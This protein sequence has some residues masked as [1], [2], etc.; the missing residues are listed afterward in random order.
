MINKETLLLRNKRPSFWMSDKEY[1]LVT[2]ETPIPTV[3]LV[4]LKKSNNIW[5]TLLLVR[6]TG[7]AKGQWCIIGGRI[8]IGETLKQ[9]IDRQAEDLKVKVKII[10]PFNPNFPGFIDDRNT[11]DKTK[12]PISLVYPAVI[13]SGK[14]RE[15]GE[16][17][18]GYKWFPI[19]K[20]PRIAYKQKL[21][22]KKTLEHLKKLK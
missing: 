10:S 1:Q 15:E 5:Q 13:T 16:E 21:Q 22:I 11:Q 12:H 14:V 9:A 19:N 7:Y 4:I 17:Y 6:K 2:K 8:W 3:N 18:K 20:L